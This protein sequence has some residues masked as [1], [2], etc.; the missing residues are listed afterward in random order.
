MNGTLRNVFLGI[1]NVEAARLGLH[2][3]LPFEGEG[4]P[5]DDLFAF[6]LRDGRSM[7]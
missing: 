7:T 4:I 6:E 5:G 1:P 2:G 3:L